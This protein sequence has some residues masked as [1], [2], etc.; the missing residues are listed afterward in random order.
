MPLLDDVSAICTALAK[1]GWAD[2]LRQVAGLNIELT[3]KALADELARK[4]NQIDRTIPGFE[5]FAADGRQAIEPGMPSRSL[6]FHALAK[7]RLGVWPEN[8]S[9]GLPVLKRFPALPE[10]EIVENYV[11]GCAPPSIA[12]LRLRADGAPLA[13]IVCV[14]EYR[15]AAQTVHQKHADMCYSRTGITR[16]GTT[17]HRYLR[18]SRGFT[19]SVDK[20]NQVRVVP[21]RYSAYIAA[22]IKGSERSFGPMRPIP[23]G[24]TNSAG[25][26]VKPDDERMFWVPLHKVFS[27]RDCI[28][29]MD[30]RLEFRS[31]HRNEK[32]RRVFLSMASTGSVNQQ[33][34]RFLN[35]FPF[36]IP[37]SELVEVSR[38]S[39]S[40]SD[41]ILP[42][43]IVI[44]P[45][46]RPLVERACFERNPVTL[47][48]APERMDEFGALEI[49]ELP[50]G[51]RK[52]P[53][54]LY[55]RT[56][57]QKVKPS[58]QPRVDRHTKGNEGYEAQLFIDR[59]GDGWVRAQCQQLGIDL[60]QSLPAY[61]IV[62]APDPYPAVKQADI[63]D[64]W[65]QSAPAE[66]KKTIFPKAEGDLP[67]EPLSD[68]RLAA[69]LMFRRTTTSLTSSRNTAVKDTSSDVGVPIFDPGDD[70]YTAIV[71]AP[72]SGRGTATQVDVFDDERDSPLP[73]GAAG[74]FAPGW[75]VSTDVDQTD[76]K[77]ITH[78]AAYGGGLPFLEDARICAALSGFWPA[79]APDA[80]RLYAMNLF[81]SVTP[82]PDSRLGWDGLAAPKVVRNPKDR[83]PGIAELY[84]LNQTDYVRQY[85]EA[86]FDFRGIAQVSAE[87]YKLWTL[88]MARVYQALG[89]TDTGAKAKWSVISF[90]LAEP[91]DTEEAHKATGSR[92]ADPYRFFMIQA[93]RVSSS[94][95]APKPPKVWVEFERSVVALATPV[96]VI[97]FDSNVGKWTVCES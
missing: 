57:A 89:A 47:H 31:D 95:S 43:S 72:H 80:S 64:W 88:L 7:P 51:T 59:T 16:I 33:A 42:S 55:V 13:L 29:A 19:G 70:S 54:F 77:R 60:A 17:E 21:C 56:R 15:P 61:S 36:V 25:A 5:D 12:E 67:V 26:A 96:T 35:E 18:E 81:P 94:S 83:S 40:L 73:D 92:L 6:L 62:A 78:L 82:I 86:G 1:N 30:L 69:N 11:Y 91:R 14:A 97:L 20:R 28:R 48:V 46:P 63:F 2:L 74:L 27:G 4:L 37:Q 22:Q 71:S 68:A 34:L 90:D 10:I 50:D 79:V 76:A 9:H 85:E 66:L 23:K 93:T 32:L 3:G 65:Q 49:A 39:A 84:S 58:S 87:D 8:Y 41:V 45:L 53:E 52:A 38:L 24:T 44:S 75:D